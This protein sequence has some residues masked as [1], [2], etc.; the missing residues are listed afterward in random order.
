M[1]MLMNHLIEENREHRKFG[2]LPSVHKNCSCQL[3]TIA[4]ESFSERVLS[5][6]NLLADTHHTRLDHDNVDKMDVL[7][8]SKRLM[9]RVRREEA[10]T[11]I[12]FRDALSVD[13]HV[14]PNEDQKN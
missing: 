2:Y 8:V 7:W 13:E 10:L 12:S 5:A 4:S 11:S 6:E 3:G 9:E 1:K 14:I